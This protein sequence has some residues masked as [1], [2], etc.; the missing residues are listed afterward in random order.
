MLN[1]DY[2][3]AQEILDQLILA[4]I[5][6]TLKFRI[7]Q[8][9]NAYS[10]CKSCRT[11]SLPVNKSK[12]TLGATMQRRTSSSYT[13]LGSTC[14]PVYAGTNLSVHVYLK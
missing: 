1:I 7:M 9:K 8:Q 10:F 14:H 4:Y 12:F 13:L 6:N 3:G 5:I 11:E 2:D